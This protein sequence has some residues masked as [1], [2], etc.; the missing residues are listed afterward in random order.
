[1][2]RV[3]G[4][5]Q[6]ELWVKS[7]L[8]LFVQTLRRKSKRNSKEKANPPHSMTLPRLPAAG[9]DGNLNPLSESANGV[10]IHV[11]WNTNVIYYREEEKG[12]SGYGKFEMARQIENR[13]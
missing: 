1:M 4:G 10:T 13:R 6:I 3:D 7:D 5:S 9:L 2:E 12:N 8:G 11:D